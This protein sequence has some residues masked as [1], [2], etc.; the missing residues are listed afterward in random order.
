[1]ARTYY[2]TSGL[3]GAGLLTSTAY[4]SSDPAARLRELTAGAAERRARRLVPPCS[5]PDIDDPYRLGDAAYARAYAAIRT[6][7]EVI[8]S[9][10][11]GPVG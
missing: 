7:V 2:S 11:I 9:R 5:E 8:A 6:A 1:M 4:G 10:V 3:S